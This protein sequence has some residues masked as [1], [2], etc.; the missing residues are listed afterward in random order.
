MI[1]VTRGDEPPELAVERAKRLPMAQQKV[2][3]GEKLA[4]TDLIGYDKARL[5]LYASQHRKCAYCEDG[6]KMPYEPV[7]HFRPALRAIRGPSFAD[8]GYWWLAWTWENLL[9]AC[10]ICN[11]SFKKDLFRLEDGSPVM[12]PME[13]LPCDE[14]AVLVDPADP[15]DVDPMDL[16]VYQPVGVRWIPTGRGGDARGAK[17][18]ELL[19]L[20][21]AGHLDRYEAHVD[22]YLQHHVDRLRSRAE[23]DDVLGFRDAWDQAIRHVRPVRPWA[24]L[25]HDVLDHYFPAAVRAQMGVTLPRP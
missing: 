7:E 9:F 8:G 4:R 21:D 10:S 24:A 20:S 11:S 1:R 19:G 2:A 15:L 23:L 25:A 22:E 13:A 3:A 18:V 16:I 17:I 6:T 12:V 14:R 5:R